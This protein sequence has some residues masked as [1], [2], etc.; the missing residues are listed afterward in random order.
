MRRKIEKGRESV[1]YLTRS[2]V[3]ITKAVPF[4]S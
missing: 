3:P 1:L 4:M 2:H